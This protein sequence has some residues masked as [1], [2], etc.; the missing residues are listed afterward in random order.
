MTERINQIA[1]FLLQ[2]FDILFPIS[3]LMGVI[4]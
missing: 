1:D 3:N 2:F 4:K